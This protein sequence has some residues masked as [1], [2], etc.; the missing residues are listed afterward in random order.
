MF[1]KADLSSG[2]WHVSLEEESSYLTTCQ[3]CFGRYWYLR[4][5]FGVNGASEYFQ[6]RL[7]N[8]L[9]GLQGVICIADDVVI[10]GA[11]NEQHDDNLR[12]FLSRCQEVGI[13]LNKEKFDLRVEAITFMGHKISSTGVHPDPEKVTA[14]TKMKTPDDLPGL[15][16]FIG[17]VTYLG[18][19]LPNLTANL[20][21]LHQLLKKDV[22]WNWSDS[23]QTAFN[24]VKTM[25]ST[26]PV[27]SYYDPEKPLTIENDACEYCLGSA[28]TQHGKPI[29]YASRSLSEAETRYAQ[30]EKEMLAMAYGLEKFHQY[31]FGREVT[32]VTDHKPLVAIAAKP[33]SRAP[34]RLQNLLLRAQ[35][36]DFEIIWKPGTKIQGP[37]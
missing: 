13:K 24:T 23:Q 3:T 33:L 25:L 17:M 35:K 31:T 4:L 15:R 27:L 32:I 29:A 5:P 2:Y 1:T 30:I 10:H 6:K 20:H 37:M 9:Q 11:T 14:I 21:P 28:L 18:K 7:I 8:S 36:Y 19:F 12:N 34:K 26:A 16:R 22:S